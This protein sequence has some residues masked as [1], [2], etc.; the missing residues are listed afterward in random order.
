MQAAEPGP[1]RIVLAEDH[2]IVREGVRALL[3]SR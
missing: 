3:A 1:L 2:R